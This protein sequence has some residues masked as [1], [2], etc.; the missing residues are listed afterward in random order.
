MN[1]SIV[2]S[3]AF[4]QTLQESAH[5]GLQ[6]TFDTVK[7]QVEIAKQAAS[8]RLETARQGKRLIDAGGE[9]MVQLLL[10]K[11]ASI[12][13]A[14]MDENVAKQFHVA[15]AALDESVSRLQAAQSIEESHGLGFSQ[16]VDEHLA[17]GATFRQ[18]SDMLNTR[19]SAA[20]MDAAQQDA[21]T[22][23]RAR[24]E[25]SGVLGKTAESLVSIKQK[26]LSNTTAKS[27]VSDKENTLSHHSSS[28]CPGPLQCMQDKTYSS[29]LAAKQSASDRLDIARG[30]KALL[31][32]GG[33]S[34]AHMVLAKK[35]SMD[36]ASLDRGLAEQVNIA[37][38]LFE[39][40]SA[41]LRKVHSEE[42][43]VGWLDVA[44]LAT[45]HDA[46]A[47]LYRQIAKMLEVPIGSS[48]LSLEEWDAIT[49]VRIREGTDSWK[50]K[51]V[52]GLQIIRNMALA[53]CAA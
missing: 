41:L 9:P 30:G 37:T 8:N 36:A 46:R 16:L 50:G 34:V 26:A 14:G 4:V 7:N 10:A 19:V 23:I 12:D 48:E 25:C 20:G 27:Y 11:K 49:L 6:S 33:D 31:D 22:L 52:E 40:S 32:K 24:A 44:D 5:A 17:R 21:I 1:G 45:E 28:V 42:N 35:A 53:G 51:T 39:Q 13:A 3:Q 43:V 18:I 2:S 29:L 38:L 15:I 47:E